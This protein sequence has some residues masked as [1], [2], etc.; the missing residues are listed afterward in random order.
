MAQTSSETSV[1]GDSLYKR[2]EH[3]HA[4]ILVELNPTVRK[5]STVVRW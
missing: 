2:Y 3:K 4:D 5:I 1:E